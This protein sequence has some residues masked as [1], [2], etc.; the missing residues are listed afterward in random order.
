[1]SA[2]LRIPEVRLRHLARQVHALG[3]RPLYELFRELVAGADPQ[4]RIQAFA[5]IDADFV[6]AL[7]GDQFFPLIAVIEQDIREV[8]NA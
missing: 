5:D 7:G 2:P 6:H 3:P 1:M 8:R 4:D